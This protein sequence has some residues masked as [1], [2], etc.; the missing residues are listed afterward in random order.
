[1]PV[2]FKCRKNSMGAY[3][4]TIGVTPWTGVIGAGDTPPEALHTA[5]AIAANLADVL[6]EHPELQAAL[7]PGTAVALRGLSVASYALSQDKDVKELEQNIGPATARL[8]NK[9]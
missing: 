6:A 1:M 2:S 3:V 8:A 7:P 9:V 4:C 5:A